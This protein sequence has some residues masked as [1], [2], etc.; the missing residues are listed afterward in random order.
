[1][2]CGNSGVT[3][4]RRGASE[5]GWAPCFPETCDDLELQAE[6]A[7][8]AQ[9]AA[10]LK[11][12]QVPSHWMT[13]CEDLDPEE[14][15]RLDIVLKRF[16]CWDTLYRWFSSRKKDQTCPWQFFSSKESNLISDFWICAACVAG[17]ASLQTGW[18][19]S[20]LQ[21]SEADPW[22]RLRIDSFQYSCCEAS[23]N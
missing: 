22:K 7:E 21:H 8:K 16:Q 12:E 1:M 4:S 10:K 5:H 15:C 17:D 2:E 14:S 20:S 23:R 3:S 18:E 9:E 13:T 6:R 11:M 19:R